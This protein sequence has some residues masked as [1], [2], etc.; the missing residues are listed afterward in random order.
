MFKNKSVF[1]W[2]HEPL[3]CN[4]EPRFSSDWDW[5]HL[6]WRGWGCPSTPIP[7]WVSKQNLMTVGSHH[8]S[9]MPDHHRPTT[10]P[11]DKTPVRWTNIN[12]HYLHA[13]RWNRP[14]W[15]KH[16]HHAYCFFFFN[17]HNKTYFTI[18]PLM[19]D[20]TSE[21]FY[22]VLSVWL[23]IFFLV[24]LGVIIIII[25]II[26]IIEEL[27]VSEGSRALKAWNKNQ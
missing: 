25:I 1:V 16:L 3:G 22:P 24:I 23:L 13:D 19:L 18:T 2:N 9:L 8:H 6:F 11:P 20:F 7:N 17:F 21:Y 14:L 10:P 4:P 26:N 12:L 5:D 27:V 15:K